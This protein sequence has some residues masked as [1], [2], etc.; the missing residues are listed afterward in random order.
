MQQVPAGVAQQAEQPPC[1]R[2]AS[3]SNPLT[4]SE[5]PAT[6]N[7]PLPS[8]SSSRIFG[9][10]RDFGRLIE[11]ITMHAQFASTIEQ[12][13]HHA[14]RSRRMMRTTGDQVTA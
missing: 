6:A 5:L 12:N 9:S 3:G 10:A 1:K 4:G 7:N 13:R 11:E 8:H 2:Q 14:V